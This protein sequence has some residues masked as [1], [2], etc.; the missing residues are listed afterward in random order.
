VTRC[1]ASQSTL[2]TTRP[3]RLDHFPHRNVIVGA[4]KEWRQLICRDPDILE[5]LK[6][7]RN[8]TDVRQPSRLM[9]ESRLPE[10][11]R[12]NGTLVPSIRVY[13]A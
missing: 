8:H 1:A 10:T 12:V 13:I 2:V 9:S 6:Q 7:V 3:L 5:V 11:L 4:A